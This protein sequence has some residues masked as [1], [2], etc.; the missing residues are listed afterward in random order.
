MATPKF[1]NESKGQGNIPEHNAEKMKKW[2]IERRITLEWKFNLGHIILFK[3]V[4]TG[5]KERKQGNYIIKEI[6][7]YFPGPNKRRKS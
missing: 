1:N 2:I 6:E 5:K 4:I 3:T 7:E